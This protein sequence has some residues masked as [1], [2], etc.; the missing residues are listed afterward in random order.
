MWQPVDG[1]FKILDIVVNGVV[2]EHANSRFESDLMSC[3]APD[4][5]LKENYTMEALDLPRHIM[6][7]ALYDKEDCFVA[8]SGI[9]RR[10]K[11]PVG[12]FRLLN[13]TFYNPKFRSQSGF[14]FYGA[15]HILPHQLKRIKTPI[16]F[17]FVSREGAY[18]GLFMK[19]LAGRKVFKDY[20]IS[21]Q[22]IQVVPDVFD[23]HS[24]QK[25]L[26]KNNTDKKMEFSGCDHLSQIAERQFKKISL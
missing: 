20:K 13:R 2:S 5:K 14:N 25:I 17:G 11:W 23:S 9:Y 26:Y 10:E 19:K 1:R 7:S 21:S 8:C 22:F 6:F 12:C 24:F 15:D 16:N 4:D 3:L 18:A